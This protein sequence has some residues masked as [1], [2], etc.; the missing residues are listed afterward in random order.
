MQWSNLFCPCERS[1]IGEVPQGEGVEKDRKDAVFLSV[2]A[3][4]RERRDS[5]KCRNAYGTNTLRNIGGYGDNTRTII[6]TPQSR[7]A[8][9]LPYIAP[10]HRGAKGYL[11]C[12]TSRRAVEPQRLWLVPLWGNEYAME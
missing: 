6:L 4:S 5:T 2:P 3:T 9:Q 10:Q 7:T 1:E 11:L 8:R 12:H